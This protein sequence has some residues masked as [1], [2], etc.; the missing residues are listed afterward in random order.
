VAQ[1]AVPGRGAGEHPGPG[2][3][4]PGGRDPRLAAFAQGDAAGRCLPGA[5]TGMVLNELSDPDRTCSGAT[6]DELIGLLGRWGAQES[7][8]VAAKLGVIRELLRRWKLT[9]PLPGWHQWETPSGRIY[10]QGPMQYPA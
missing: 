3:G 5:W 7:W 2:A 10:T 6:D 9:Q 4:L 1:S 8:T